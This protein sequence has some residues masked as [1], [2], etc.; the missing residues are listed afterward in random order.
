MGRIT[1]ELPK[2]LI[3]SV[4]FNMETLSIILPYSISVALVGIVESLLT[5]QLLDDLTDTPSDKNKE[6]IGQGLANLVNGFLVE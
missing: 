2:F 3:P 6:C 4:P 1:N 5:A